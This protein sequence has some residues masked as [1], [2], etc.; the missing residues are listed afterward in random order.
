MLLVFST[1]YII[2]FCE[3]KSLGTYNWM[4]VI[5]EK[6]NKAIM[7]LWGFLFSEVTCLILLFSVA[8]NAIE[9]VDDLVCTEGL[10][11]PYKTIYSS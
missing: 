9:R 6:E 11:C 2:I 7:S 1:K 10:Y 5:A 3:N 8:R 4:V